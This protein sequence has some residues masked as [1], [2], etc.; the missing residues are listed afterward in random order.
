ML[1]LSFPCILLLNV[2]QK[3]TKEHFWIK[4]R[5]MIY[6]FFFF[7]AAFIT[8][9]DVLSQTIVGLPLIFFFELQ[10][11]FWTLYKKYQK[12]IIN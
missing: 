8:P 4:Y 10:I 7:S 3:N 12:A 9:P 11:I 5:G 6:I 2:I 1:S